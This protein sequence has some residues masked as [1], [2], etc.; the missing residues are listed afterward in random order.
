MSLYSYKL[1]VVIHAQW[2]IEASSVVRRHSSEL[3]TKPQAS[4]ARLG[5]EDRKRASRAS[6]FRPPTSEARFGP[7]DLS[8]GLL[9]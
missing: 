6:S 3:N 9:G 8:R 1:V 7:E 2:H 4:N 5:K